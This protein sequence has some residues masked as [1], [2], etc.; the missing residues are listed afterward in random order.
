[1]RRLEKQKK[2][3]KVQMWVLE[4]EGRW[5]AGRTASKIDGRLVV[6]DE[7]G[8]LVRLLVGEMIGICD[9]AAEGSKVPK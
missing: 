1:L 4:W 5:W 3:L 2:R 7:L 9:G 6:G 8:L